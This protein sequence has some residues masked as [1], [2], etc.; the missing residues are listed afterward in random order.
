MSTT[1]TVGATVVSMT[2]DFLWADEFQWFPVEQSTERTLTGGLVVD[3]RAMTGGRPITLKG[4]DDKSSWIPRAVLSQLTTWL[5][6]PGQ[7][8]TLVLRG[9]SYTVIW[10]HHEA[11]AL[12][13][14]PVIDFS[15][16]GPDDWYRVTLKLM[17]VA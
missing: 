6:T 7:Q 2:D 16:I 9:V 5:G 12:D 1:L 8:M 10:R 3:V 13:A 15:D 14:S 17:V 11:P 4:A